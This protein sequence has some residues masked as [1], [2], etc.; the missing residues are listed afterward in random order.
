[1]SEKTESVEITAENLKK[2]LDFLGITDI[3]NLEKG[4]TDKEIGKKFEKEPDNK[5]IDGNE[6]KIENSDDLNNNSDKKE[7]SEKDEEKKEGKESK[8]EDEKE[9]DDIDDKKKK[10]DSKDKKDMSKEDEPIEKSFNNELFEKSF[11]QLEEFYKA[12]VNELKQQNISLSTQM[13]SQMEKIETLLSK[14][15]QVVEDKFSAVG[16]LEKA[17]LG[18]HSEL[19]EKNS[20]LKKSIGEIRQRLGIIEE[21][22]IPRKAIVSQAQAIE[23]GFDGGFGDNMN[24][25]TGIKRMSLKTD[26]SALIDLLKGKSGIDDTVQNNNYMTALFEYESSGVISKAVVNDLF[27]NDKIL[28]T[29]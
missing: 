17:I 9:E 21:Q 5:D 19:K 20:E 25:G 7:D 11:S 27:K 24:L 13:D 28:I 16:E 3:F 26:R 10:K 2:S 12:E 15:F 8:K 23:K 29:Q 14:G 1:M 18:E 6:K 4:I 22:P